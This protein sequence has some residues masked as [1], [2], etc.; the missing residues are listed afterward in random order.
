[1]PWEALVALFLAVLAG[2]ISHVRLE[3][4]QNSCEKEALEI[5]RYAEREIQDLRMQLTQ[6]RAAHTALD[7][8]IMDELRRLGEILAELK[9]ILKASNE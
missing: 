5:K 8:K 9:G 4:R 6:A 1:M 7:S 2:I 3:G